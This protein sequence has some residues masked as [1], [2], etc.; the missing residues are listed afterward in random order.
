MLSI[1]A[2]TVC[3]AGTQTCHQER[4]YDI[5]TSVCKTVIAQERI[6]EWLNQHP[7]YEF[8]GGLSCIPV[9]KDG[10]ET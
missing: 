1:L 10:P 8:T 7:K 4:I 9:D 6:I 5:K 3:L 2:F